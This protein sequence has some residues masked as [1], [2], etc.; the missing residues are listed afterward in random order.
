MTSVDISHIQKMIRWLNV[1]AGE[2]L[3]LPLGEQ[4]LGADEL[5]LD[6]FNDLD[7]GWCSPELWPEEVLKEF[8]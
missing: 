1:A 5:L 8:I 6:W 3:M 2:G 7:D 4:V